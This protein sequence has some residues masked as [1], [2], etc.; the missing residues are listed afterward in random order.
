LDGKPLREPIWLEMKGS[1]MRSNQSTGSRRAHGYWLAALLTPAVLAAPLMLGGSAQAADGHPVT[2]A[3]QPGQATVQLA[4][5]P[6]PAPAVSARTTARGLDAGCS[7]TFGTASSIVE[8]HNGPQPLGGT[9][10]AKP[11]VSSCNDLNLDYVGASDYY[12]GF[13]YWTSLGRWLP[14]TEGWVR[15]P[16]GYQNAQYPPVLCTGVSPGTAMAVATASGNHWGIIVE[17]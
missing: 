8:S 9:I 13:L 11:A 7:F 14:C 12:E 6:G 3:A 15:I 5:R 2:T 4:A 10:F 16:A 1:V 17:D